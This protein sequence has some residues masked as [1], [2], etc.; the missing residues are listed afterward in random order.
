MKGFLIDIDGVLKVGERPVEGAS[1]FIDYLNRKGFPFVLVT[2]NSTRTPEEVSDRLQRMGLKVTPEHILTSALATALYLEHNFSRGHKVYVIGENGL[3][4]ALEDIDWEIL[5]DHRGA[6]FVVIGLDRKCTYEKIR[7][8]IRAILMENARFVASNSDR[9]M[10]SEDGP[11]PGA[12]TIVRAVEYATGVTPVV[13]G[14]P[15][16]FIGRIAIEKLGSPTP[17]EL[18]VIGD[19]PETD[20]ALARNIG[21]RAVLVLSGVTSP[22]ALNDL[23][24]NLKPDIVVKSVRGLLES[25]E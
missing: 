21:A 18:Y 17:D 13:I 2:N 14:K 24:E 20:V 19:R 8:A 25:L 7:E 6:G 23:P 9:T 5:P 3:R 10:P 4:S 1:D 22:Y 15:N 12:G 16:P 11:M